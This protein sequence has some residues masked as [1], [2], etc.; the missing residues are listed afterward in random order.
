MEYEEDKIPA[1]C[2]ECASGMRPSRD[3]LSCITGYMENCDIYKDSFETSCKECKTN[4][5]PLI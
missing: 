1:E 5:T 3:N 2:I 4:E